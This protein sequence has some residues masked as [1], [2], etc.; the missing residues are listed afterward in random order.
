MLNIIKTLK[1]TEVRDS[2]TS[3]VNSAVGNQRKAAKIVVEESSI[4]ESPLP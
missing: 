2:D 4:L 3:S 1:A